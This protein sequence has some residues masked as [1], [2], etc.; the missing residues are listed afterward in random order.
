[1]KS[2]I[3]NS[4]VRI[5][6]KNKSGFPPYHSGFW[7]LASEFCFSGELPMAV[8]EHTYKTYSGE[9]TPR[10]S[11]FLILPRHS[12][13]NIFQSKLFIAV[14][15]VCFIYPLVASILIYLH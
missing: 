13:R 5:Q 2:R 1:M 11:R 15:A 9:V 8:Y 3:Q 14:F 10:W 12:Y 6:N 4:G 7:L